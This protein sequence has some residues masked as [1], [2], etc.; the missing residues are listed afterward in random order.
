[1]KEW[2]LCS[3]LN[4][5]SFHGKNKLI[6]TLLWAVV[7]ASVT[8]QQVDGNEWVHDESVWNYPATHQFLWVSAIVVSYHS[9]W[10]L[11]TWQV[12]HPPAGFIGRSGILICFIWVYCLEQNTPN[13]NVL[14]E[15]SCCSAGGGTQQGGGER[16]ND[17]DRASHHGPV[18]HTGTR[19]VCLLP[20]P[21][22]ICGLQQV[23]HYN[24]HNLL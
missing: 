4:L 24:Y 9:M 13:V 11:H 23:W 5:A 12:L 18:H 1:M 3:L 20:T 15:G 8:Q 19:P 22:K 17:R 10:S 2:L 21:H 14:L 16:G 7:P 6:I